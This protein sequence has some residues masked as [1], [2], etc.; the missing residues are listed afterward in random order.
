MESQAAVFFL[1]IWPD[2][3][4]L[5]QAMLKFHQLKSPSWFLLELYCDIETFLSCSI[6]D[7]QA[8][9]DHPKEDFSR[10]FPYL[11]V[12]QTGKTLDK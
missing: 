8:I 6:P 3:S 4:K 5:P 10:L 11:Q 1:S 2:L 9:N 12:L 7:Q